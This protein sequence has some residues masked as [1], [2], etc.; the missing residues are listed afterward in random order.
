MRT[1]SLNKKFDVV[2]SFDGMM[3]NL[4]YRDLEKTIK[5]LARHLAEGGVLIFHLDRLRENFKQFGI[6]SNPEG[7]QFFR[8]NTYLT[9][10]Q[11]DYDKDTKDNVFESCLVF[12]FAKKGRNMKVKVDIE[13]MGMFELAKIKKILS[14]LGF[15]VFVY[16]GDF[17]GKKYSDKSPCPVF[18][19]VRNRKL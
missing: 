14:N 13:K 3:Y 1:F 19:C 6:I 10:F 2:M 16:S 5:N 18:V 11:I 7:H 17:S 4:N 9:Y 8:G 12:I 15:K